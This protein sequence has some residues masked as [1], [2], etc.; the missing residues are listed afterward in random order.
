M[1]NSVEENVS[2]VGLNIS[3][4][5]ARV[6]AG[7]EHCAIMEPGSGVSRARGAHRGREHSKT[8]ARVC[9]VKNLDGR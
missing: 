8:R 5:P 6:T 7:N 1:A 3:A 9:R 2:V 4:V